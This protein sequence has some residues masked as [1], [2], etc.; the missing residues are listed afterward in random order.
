MIDAKEA[1]FDAPEK[2]NVISAPMSKH[3]RNVHA[4]E[5]VKFVNDLMLMT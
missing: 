5:E 1:K 4:I 2:P 3:G